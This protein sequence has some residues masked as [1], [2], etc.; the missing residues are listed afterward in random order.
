MLN[1]IY[2]QLMPLRAD[3]REGIGMSNK[4]VAKAIFRTRQR[5]T[6]FVGAVRRACY[7]ALGVRI[8]RTSLP[9]AL[10]M[11]WPHRVRIGD[12]CVI[13]RGVTLKV[14]G[15]YAPE[16]AIDIGSRTFIGSHVEFNVKQSVIVGNDCLIASGCR[17]VD[18]DHGMVLD[19]GPIGRQA[20]CVEPI[21]VGNDVWLGFGVQ[22]LKGVHIGNGVVVAA[23]AV[24]TKSIPP[25]EIWGGI[26]ARKL[27]DRPAHAN[28]A[29]AH[30]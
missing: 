8:G 19:A 3:H 21:I 28:A 6:S 12:G 20:A 15:I 29:G 22:V 23:G 10:H 7:M 17:F 5:F 4:F 9:H 30:E 18:Q 1:R 26:P 24:V 16:L 13:E 27:A 25:R 2:K 11:T 14:D